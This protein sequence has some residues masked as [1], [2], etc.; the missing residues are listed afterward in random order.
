MSVKE[1]SLAAGTLLSLGFSYLPGLRTWFEALEAVYKR[2]VMLGLLL[3]AATAV[4]CLACL[5]EVGKELGLAVSC[6]RGG[7]I[8]LLRAFILA[9]IANQSTFLISPR[10]RRGGG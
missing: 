2:L 7:G 8:G 4:F 3:A 1:L 6:D 9:A 5:G 10:P